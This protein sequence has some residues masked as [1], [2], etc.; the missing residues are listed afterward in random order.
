MLFLSGVSIRCNISTRTGRS[1]TSLTIGLST[2]FA[3]LRTKMRSVV[4]TLPREIPNSSKDSSGWQNMTAAAPWKLTRGY[5]RLP[6]AAKRLKDGWR[7]S[8]IGW[9]TYTRTKIVQVAT[10][11]G[12]CW[13]SR[14]LTL[15]SR[16]TNVLWAPLQTLSW[17]FRLQASSVGSQCPCVGCLRQPGGLPCHR[18]SRS[19]RRQGRRQGA[20]RS[21]RRRR[22]RP[23]MLVSIIGLS[24]RTCWGLVS[25]RRHSWR[26]LWGPVFPQERCLGLM[27][28][29]LIRSFSGR[30][31]LSKR[32]RS[33]RT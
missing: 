14:T 9:K 24:S 20:T 30:R 29:Q 31:C 4:N 27:P 28:T 22:R 8:K 15:W 17:R 10:R 33:S 16:R 3:G 19:V 1:G 32:G 13:A 18:R 11:A 12:F 5:C 25:I 26:A 6:P 23:D 2:I 21:R 7:R